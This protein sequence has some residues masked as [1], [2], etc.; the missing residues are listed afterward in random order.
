MLRVLESGRLVQG[1]HVQQLEEGFARLHGARFAVATSNGTAALTAALLAHGVGP[2][3]EVI[4]PAFS[5]FATA[6]SVMSIGATP[7]FVDIH[8]EVFTLDPELVEAAIGPRTRAVVPVHLYGQPADLS[9]LESLC[10]RSGLSL[11]Q[12]A[13]QAHLATVGGR[14]LGS[15]G[16]ACFSFYASKN[17]TT[18]EGGMVITNDDVMAQRLR[19]LRNQGRNAKGEHE[20]LGGNWRMTEIAAAIGVVQLGRLEQGTRVRAENA[21]FY[22]ERLKTDPRLAQVSAPRVAEG[23]GHVFHQYTIEL[24]EPLDR[25]R[26]VRHLL[27]SGIEARVYYP[28]GMHREPLIQ[29]LALGDRPL[30][31]TDRAAQRVLS[32]PVHPGVGPVERELV[33]ESLARAVGA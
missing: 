28:R 8:P 19:M 17:M 20:L 1:E 30:P 29:R 24:Q 12:D 2:S 14:R 15:F 26:V 6:S 22:G 3:D 21:A 5:F 27:E 4:L 7:V 11:I 13:A 9:R 10:Q 16:S 23:R 32:L 18:G 25:T 31:H 33:M